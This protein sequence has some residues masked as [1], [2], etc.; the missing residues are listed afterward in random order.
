MKKKTWSSILA[1]VL[2]ASLVLTACGK[3]PAPEPSGGAAG[4]GS[5]STAPS[6]IRLGIFKNVTHAAGYVALEQGLFKKYWGE[7]VKIEVQAFDNGSDFSTAIATDQIDLG[8]VGPGPATNQFL[9][10]KNFRI[11]SGSNNGG[12][13]LVAGKD[14]GI[15]SPKDLV[16]KTVAIP[17]KGSTNEI[18]LRLLLK[19]NGLSVTTD[20]TGV[21]IIARAP[22]DTLIAMRQKE[23]D[24]TLIP[25][26]WGTQMEQEGI[27]KVIVPWDQVPPNK[28]NYPLTLLVA[29]DKFLKQHREA[30]KQAIQANAEAIDF[31]KANPDK[32]YELINNRLKELSGKGMDINLIKAAL[33]H[34]NLTTDVSKEAVEE[35]AKVSIDAGYIKDVKKEELD[36]GKFLDLSL[37]Q[38]VKASK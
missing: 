38:E 8:Y 37:L 24:A 30:A 19:E 27:G 20:K 33:S 23:I 4:G 5:A 25:E 7:N 35:M 15:N 16:G 28:G 31:I 22:A 9:K 29:S 2:G 10:S 26:P 6:T 11:I 34:L 1:I 13:V 18:S 36:L 32:S 3:Q 17:T 14:S 12:A 21:Q